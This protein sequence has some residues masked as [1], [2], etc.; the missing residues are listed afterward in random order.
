MA[1]KARG[2]ITFTPVLEAFKSTVFA[3]T[4]TA[5]ATPTGGSYES[6]IPEYS[7]TQVW[8]DGIPSGTAQIWASSCT[9]YSDGTNT[10]WTTPRP[11][12]D[13]DTSDIEFSPSVTQPNPPTGSTPFANHEAEGWYDPNSASFPS[14]GEMIWRA[15]RKVKN[16]VFDGAWVIS[17]VRGEKGDTGDDSVFVSFNP[18]PYLVSDEWQVYEIDGQEVSL[19]D[20]KTQLFIKK[21]ETDITFLRKGATPTYPDVQAE[22]EE[23]EPIWPQDAPIHIEMLGVYAHN[24]TSISGITFGYECVETTYVGIGRRYEHFI[25]MT[26]LSSVYSE[27]YLLLRV[28][29]NTTIGGETVSHTEDV[30]L[31]FNV[32]HN[33]EESSAD[34]FTDTTAGWNAALGYI[35]PA[36]AIIVYTDYSTKEVDGQTVN[37]PGIKIG[38]GNGYVQDL[39]FVDEDVRSRL[40]AHIS[41][42]VSH[43]TAAERTAW[44]NKLNVND[45]SEVVNEALV[46]NRN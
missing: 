36:G 21:G 4:N 35:P 29:V 22:G 43:I 44:N 12:S 45:N 19:P 23:P 15:E 41:D 2:H 7:G 9:F 28:S 31:F 25:Q 38:S 39:A 24:G 33:Q 37:I 18:S 10:G 32:L 40:M 8:F 34:I 20:A 6:P 46:L 26:G 17:R 16:G 5:P 1:T 13:T 27:G 3:R 11:M 42:N 14:A 30:K